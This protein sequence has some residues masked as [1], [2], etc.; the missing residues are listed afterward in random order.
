MWKGSP[1]EQILKS[2]HPI[3]MHR[4]VL[5]TFEEMQ[6]GP[7][8]LTQKDIDALVKKDPDRYRSLR[9]VSVLK[10]VVQQELEAE[11]QGSSPQPED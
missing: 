8:P 9:S 7:N 10:E 6:A 1:E 4:R 11:G 3:G 2:T 5:E